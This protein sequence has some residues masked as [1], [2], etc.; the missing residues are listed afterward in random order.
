M[1]K[2]AQRRDHYQA[3]AQYQLGVAL[4]ALGKSMTR[5]LVPAKDTKPDQAQVEIFEGISDAGRLLADLHHNFSHTR[6]VFITPN[7]KQLAVNVT[8]EVK[9]DEYLYG[10]EFSDKLKAAKEVERVSKDAT[11]LDKGGKKAETSES[12]QH[13][14]PLRPRPDLNSGGL[15]R[16][17]TSGSRYGRRPNRRGS[18]GS[19]GKPHPR[20]PRR[21]R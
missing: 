11:K 13:R 1:S 4:S 21:H 8:G 18:P 17:T 9:I 12:R 19:R 2:P 7:L 6:R 3:Q 14:P 15:P 10:K 20:N 5:M 16:Q